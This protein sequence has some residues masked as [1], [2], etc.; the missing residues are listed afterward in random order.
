MYFGT[1]ILD[2]AWQQAAIFFVTAVATASAALVLYAGTRFLGCACS[3][4]QSSA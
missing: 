4:R 1:L 2:Y 3:A